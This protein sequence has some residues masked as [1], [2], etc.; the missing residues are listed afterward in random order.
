MT[1][2]SWRRAAALIALAVPL[3]LAPAFASAWSDATHVYLAKHTQKASDQV[4]PT[5][6]CNRL[7][8]S[9]AVDMFAYDFTVEG[10]TFHAILHD[11]SLAV[12]ALPYALAANDVE[13]AL[14]FGLASHNN[15]WG[16][17]ATAHVDG[18]TAGNR[19]GYV[20]AK[21][22]ALAA[23][24]WFNGA[25]SQLT[26]GNEE[27]LLLVSHILVEYAIDLAV[28]RIDP[29]VGGDLF[30]AG[31]AC[32]GPGS[33][34][35]VKAWEPIFSNYASG[36]IAAKIREA[37]SDYHQWVAAYGM[38]LQQPNAQQ[39]VAGAVAK[40]AIEFLRLPQ[41]YLPAV[42][43]LIDGALGQGQQLVAADLQAELDATVGWVNGRMSALK[44]TP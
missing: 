32:P 30:V 34:L 7:Y 33:E 3:V 29:A 9:V 43:Q 38:A 21:A 37:D 6:L 5:E 1:N 19:D 31:Y 10:Q 8:G 35:L 25:V 39:L 44:I 20:I 26:G 16:T 15:V 27:T 22:K 18:I 12:P 11:R 24:P 40:V 36:D 2:R 41:E 17:D 28:A 14:G 42:T 23:V 13:R 4:T